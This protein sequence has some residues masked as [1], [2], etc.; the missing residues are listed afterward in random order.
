M[1]AGPL[2]GALSTPEDAWHT[3]DWYAVHRTVRRLQAR[4]VKAVQA[5]RWGKVRALQHLLTH[6]FSGKAMAVKRVTSNDG[7]RTPGVD[8]IIWETPEKKA[9]AMQNLRQRGYRA[10]PLRRIYIPKNGSTTRLRPLSIPT[11]H[12]RAM[13]ALYLLALDPIAETQGD[14][15]SY[16]FRTERSTADAIEQCFIVLSKKQSA[17]WILEGDIRAC[18]DGISHDWLLT[19]IPM[20]RVMLKKWLM[21]GFI[22]KQVLYLT[23][24]G[25]PQGGICSPV[26]A[27]LALDG[28]ERLLRQHYTLTTKR[29]QQAKVHLTR[30]ADDFIISGCSYELLQ[31]EV[32]PLVERFLRQ[33]GLELSP[34]KTHITHIEDGFD[35]LG[36]NVRKYAGKLLI[37]PA[38]KNVK[39]FLGKVRQVVKANKQATAAN[40]IAQLNPMI[41]GWA[42]Y[43]RHVVSKKT[44]YRVDTA[45]FKALWS[46]AKRRH[47]KK[48]R[49]WVADKYF[50]TRNGRAW[51][52]V[53]TS[54]DSKGKPDELT[55]V[56]AGDTPIKRHVKIK[57]AANPYDPEWEMYFEK[58]LGVKMAHQLRGRRQLLH[59]WQQQNGLCPVCHQKITRLTG[60]HNHHLVWRTHG[61]S[62]TADNRV[63]LHPNCHRQVH[64]Q[65]LDVA[66]PRSPKS[67]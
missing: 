58:R 7:K 26:I 5:G 20:D 8:G 43:H 46:W 51:T 41:R 22:D 67:V 60:W 14:A 9:C 27:N 11:M 18:F 54:V 47:P 66:P 6:S 34:E 52:F 23:E 37:K 62:D 44:F 59:L 53:G 50:A 36:Q 4:I 45:I 38:R 12:D 17:P 39:T 65:S 61:G 48:P 3:I 13:Q 57:G 21:A 40:V 49:R 32:K 25:V 63:L 16:G 10:Q 33:R 2:A 35:F 42:N 1:T 55:L 15:N 24:A 31:E 29:G 30:Y 19:Y 64:N 56:R 28:L